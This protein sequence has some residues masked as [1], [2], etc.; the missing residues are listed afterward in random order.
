MIV[1]WVRTYV[2]CDCNV[3]ILSDLATLCRKVENKVTQTSD[4]WKPYML[5]M[6][7]KKGCSDPRNK[8]VIGSE[9]QGMPG[10][11]SDIWA[12]TAEWIGAW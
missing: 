12:L 8:H 3:V 5:Q 9:G 1:Y 2:V 10:V 7:I 6:K 4:T 11:E